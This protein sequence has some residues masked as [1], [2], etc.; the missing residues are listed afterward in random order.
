[1]NGRP[2]PP[3]LARR[4][5]RAS[6]DSEALMAEARDLRVAIASGPAA[7]ALDDGQRLDLERLRARAFA[8]YLEAREVGRMLDRAEESAARSEAS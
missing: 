1:M 3:D 2:L 8:V 4:L 7:V 5:A 6:R